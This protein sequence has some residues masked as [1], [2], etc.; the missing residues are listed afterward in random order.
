MKATL[1]VSA[2]CVI[3]VQLLFFDIFAIVWWLMPSVINL[4]LALL[5]YLKIKTKFG[6]LLAGVGAIFV[7]FIL[8]FN[9]LF[10]NTIEVIKSNVSLQKLAA[11]RPTFK[12]ERGAKIKLAGDIQEIT[13]QIKE[14]DWPQYESD[15][16]P[17]F[18][19]HGSVSRGHYYPR[20]MVEDFS[21]QLKLMRLELAPIDEAQY[22]LNIDK[23]SD[24]GLN[25]IQ[26]KLLKGDQVIA[27]HLVYR[28]QTTLESARQ[29]YSERKY[30][31]YVDYLMNNTFW[32][33]LVRS[34]FDK[35]KGSI[36][37]EF[38]EDR[39]VKPKVKVVLMGSPAFKFEA[40]IKGGGDK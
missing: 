33:Y 37:R 8:A 14:L 15:L 5:F 28:S 32:H 22:I 36:I 30:R 9:V 3:L 38:F 29:V 34:K 7:S 17:A 6:V 18:R 35:H 13:F 2:L 21:Q 31:I 27:K 40:R 10:I 39:I 12:I 19:F 16:G 23:A 20:V 1:T 11:E 4:G 26:L 24:Y 25:Y